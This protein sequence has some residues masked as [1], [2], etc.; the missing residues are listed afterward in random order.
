[1][2]NDVSAL[3]WVIVWPS[4]KLHVYVEAFKAFIHEALRREMSSSCLIGSSPT[5]SIPSRGRIYQDQ[6]ASID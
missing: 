1:M 6:V 4:G 2:I 3:F 5:A